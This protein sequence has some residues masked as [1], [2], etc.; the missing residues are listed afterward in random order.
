MDIFDSDGFKGKKN[1]VF[2]FL[3]FTCPHYIFIL[4][5]EAFKV[6]MYR[7]CKKKAVSTTVSIGTHGLGV[8]AVQPYRCALWCACMQHMQ[9]INRFYYFV[10]V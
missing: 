9:R 5:E 3:T 1:Q 6:H 8:L 10:L 4:K 7:S 2:C